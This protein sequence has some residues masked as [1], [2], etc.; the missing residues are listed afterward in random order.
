MREYHRALSK[1][2]ISVGAFFRKT[3]SKISVDGLTVTK[4]ELQANPTMVVSTHRSHVDYMLLGVELN[5]AGIQNIRMAAGDNLT[6]MPLLGRRFLSYGAFSVQRAR[7]NSRKYIMELCRTVIAMLENGDTILVFP[8]GG[9]SYTGKMMNMKNG[10][11]AA[12]IFAQY[13]FLDKKFVYLP[14][15]I[16]YEKPPELDYFAMLNR[17]RRIK[18]GHSPIT[19]YLK[20]AALYY[21]AD[22]LAFITYINAHRFKKQYGDVYI[23]YGKPLAIKELVDLEKNHSPR[24]RNDF[25]AHK[26]SIQMI[27]EIIGKELLQL[28]RIHPLHVVSTIIKKVGSCTRSDAESR[29]PAIMK[30]LE[31]NNRNCKTLLSFT[32]KEIV[33]KG[34]DK[35]LHFNVLSEKGRKLRIKNRSAIKYYAATI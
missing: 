27:S 14:V 15:T 10:I 31:E 32:E 8:E 30:S 18:S 1:A 35:L 34:V 24:A 25:T 2:A 19:K 21:G 3:Y 4:K 17:G 13:K 7:A 29:V 26:I 12:N 9:R 33:Q 5:R 20:G 6:K 11:L 23:D 22:I 28:Y 16:S